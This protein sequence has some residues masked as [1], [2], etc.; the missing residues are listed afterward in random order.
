M[1]LLSPPA[2]VC[3]AFRL[4]LT[5]PV[6]PFRHQRTREEDRQR[7]K[8]RQRDMERERA[9]YVKADLEGHDSDDERE[10]WQRR[11]LRHS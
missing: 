9:R 3:A 7:E 6:D 4:A 8:D 1:P 2:A 10:P 11:S 5:P